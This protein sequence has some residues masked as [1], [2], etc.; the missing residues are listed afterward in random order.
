VTD[1]NVIGTIK[2]GWDY[3]EPIF[4]WY[5]YAHR[6]SIEAGI[7]LPEHEPTGWA[8]HET[9]GC[10]LE[11]WVEVLDKEVLKREGGM[12]AAPLDEF[13]KWQLHRLHTAGFE[14]HIVTARGSL[15]DLGHL[16]KDLTLR[17]IEREGL[18]V[19]S[20]TF[21]K[22]KPAAIN[23]LGL[24]YFIDDAPHNITPI[25]EQCPNTE[26]YLLD[27]RWNRD[28]V[29]PEGRR[30]YSVEEYVDIILAKHATV[31]V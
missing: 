6:A 17:Q 20:V 8:P 14:N 26:A 2:V 1:G 27:E 15:G 21:N 24:Q 29:V 5:D 10:T 25:F 3:D 31:T 22:D 28:T 11:E 19:A 13:T 23:E 4:K 18:P 12:Y 16:V 9:Y 30:L 7:A